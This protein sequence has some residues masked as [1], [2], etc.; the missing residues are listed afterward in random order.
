MKSHYLIPFVLFLL[1]SLNCQPSQTVLNDR[2]PTPEPSVKSTP[3]IP[4]D[5]FQERLKSVQ[6]G[7]FD[8]VFVF[9]R[10]DADVF[11]AEDKQF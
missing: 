4:V 5:D 11:T 10:K 3:E 9:R 7:G 8:F 1:I 2:Q 6:T